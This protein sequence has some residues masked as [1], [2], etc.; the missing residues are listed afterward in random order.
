MENNI[1]FKKDCLHNPKLI[2]LGQAKGFLKFFLINVHVSLWAKLDYKM[3]L[4]RR[5]LFSLL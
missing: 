4:E 3:E 2:V 1:C 5:K